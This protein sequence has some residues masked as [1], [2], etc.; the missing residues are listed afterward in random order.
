MMHQVALLVHHRPYRPRETTP[1][2]SPTPT[3]TPIR[4]QTPTQVF[5]P[6]PLT[7]TPRALLPSWMSHNGGAATVDDQIYYVSLDPVGQYGS[8]LIHAV[9]YDPE[10]DT[11]AERPGG[12]QPPVCC[13]PT[14]VTSATNG[15]IYAIAGTLGQPPAT[16]EYDPT[17]DT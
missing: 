6:P 16:L 12:V 3:L 1:T 15:K 17:S 10:N 9:I 5:T 4:T 13:G 7:W 8:D 2:S 14:V 11:W